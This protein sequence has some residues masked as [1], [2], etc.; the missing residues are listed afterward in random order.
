MNKMEHTKDINDGISVIM[1][2]F[3]QASFIR[4][5]IVSLCCQTHQHWELIIINDGSTDGLEEAISS[6]L[7]DERIRVFHN[8]S[9]EGLGYSLNKGI[10]NSTYDYIAYL[11]ADDIYYKNHLVTLLESITLGFDLAHAGMICEFQNLFGD[12]ANFGKKIYHKPENMSFQLIQVLHRK[13]SERWMERN[14]LESDDLDTLFW[15]NYIQKHNKTVGTREITCEWTD[16]PNQRHKIMNERYGGGIYLFKSYYNIQHPIRFENRFGGKIDEIEQY[17]LY[18]EKLNYRENGLKILLVGELSYNPERICAFEELGH[19]LYGLWINR[20]THFNAIG[21]LPFGNVEDISYENWE[22][23]VREIK[24]DIIYALLNDFSVP[25]A[26]EVLSANLPIPFVWHFKEGPFFSR[27]CGWWNKLVDLYQKSDGQIYNNEMI[28][29]W[30]LQFITPIHNK[31]YI[32]DGDLQKSTWFTEERSS[33]LSDKD[34]EIHVVIA[35]RP[36]GITPDHIRQMGKQKIHL[37][38]YGNN[39]ISRY[40][41]LLKKGKALAPNYLHLHNSCSAKDFVKEF[42][43]Y[44]AGFL[45]N[46]QSENRGELLRASWNDLNFP[47]RMSTYG[48]AGLP[49]LVYNN[50]GHRVATQEFLEQYGMTLKYTSISQLSDCF[51]D[52]DKLLM[53]RENVWNHRNIFSFDYHVPKL[54]DFFHQVILSKQKKE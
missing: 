48:M 9:N 7:H 43:Q 2:V 49:M 15:N 40:E 41:E 52:K 1:P 30:F 26:H 46:F 45:H 13:T 32:L 22:K 18:R 53:I 6:F 16:H 47:A 19:K 36:F 27:S 42:S 51:K 54:I 12:G 11:P 50:D 17:K 29:D 20:P 34:G 37:H 38:I 4:R 21:P 10:D 33:L 25:L 23:R 5:A 24:P 28:R 35:G 39:A 14:E 44:D 3:N 8:T 31:S